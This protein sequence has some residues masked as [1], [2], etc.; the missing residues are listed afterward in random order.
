[1][2]GRLLL[3]VVVRESASIFELFAGENESLLVRWDTLL[4]LDLGLDVLDGIRGLDLKSDGL[5]C[6]SLDEDLHLWCVL[7]FEPKRRKVFVRFCLCSL[8][9][10][11]GRKPRR[12]FISEPVLSLASGMIQ[13]CRVTRQEVT[14]NHTSLTMTLVPIAFFG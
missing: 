6:Q 4:V 2:K 7:A 3:D 5:S 8:L 12:C 13:K 9:S 14:K 11:A 10:S 1:M